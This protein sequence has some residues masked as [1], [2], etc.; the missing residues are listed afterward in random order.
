MSRYHVQSKM[1]APQTRENPYAER[2][3]EWVKVAETDSYE[4]AVERYH[5]RIGRG[6]TTRIIDTETGEVVL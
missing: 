1:R 4:S 6:F 3:Y 2:R 5:G